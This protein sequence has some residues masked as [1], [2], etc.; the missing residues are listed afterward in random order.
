MKKLFCQVY[1]ESFEVEAINFILATQSL[2][3]WSHDVIHSLNSYF[4]HV[5]ERTHIC[6]V[7]P[8]SFIGG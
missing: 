7:T 8:L 3:D 1:L 4:V 2:R 6:L 5:F